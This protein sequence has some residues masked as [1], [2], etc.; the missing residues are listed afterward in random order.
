[1]FELRKQAVTDSQCRKAS[2]GVGIYSAFE[3]L[4]GIFQVK[5]NR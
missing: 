1:M 3:R 2:E 5:G 4:G